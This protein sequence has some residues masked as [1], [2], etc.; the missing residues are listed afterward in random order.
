MD[1]RLP[2]LVAGL[3]FGAVVSVFVYIEPAPTVAYE[4]PSVPYCMGQGQ[5]PQIEAQAAYVYDVVSGASVGVRGAHL[6]II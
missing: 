1:P 2:K 3:L 6:K 5:S 4:P